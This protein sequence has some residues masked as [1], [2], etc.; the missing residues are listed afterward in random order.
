VAIQTLAAVL[1][2]TQSLHTNSRDEALSLP[3]EESVRVALR[4]QQIVA[5]ESGIT[6][7]VDPLA[8]SF[9]I[10]NLTNTIE[11]KVWDYLNKIE[12]LGGMIPAIENGYVQKE[13]QDAAYRYQQEIEKGERI[14]IGVN[15][16]ADTD[17]N[18][19]D[20][21]KVDPQLRSTQIEKL[22]RIKQRRNDERVNQ[23]L[24]ELRAA[25][26]ASD[27]NLLPFILSAVKEYATLGEICDILRA[28]FGEYQESIVL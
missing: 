3:T 13:I 4:T 2:G 10:E 7:T 17:T 8:G 19:V 5:H 27:K 23:T 21:L 28:E 1:G 24:A 15:K 25:A 20:I 9:F 12:D 22:S 14:V 26:K 16:F 18:P 6:N 11:E